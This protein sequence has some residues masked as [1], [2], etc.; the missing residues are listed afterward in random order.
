MDPLALLQ[1]VGTS[2]HIKQNISKRA[3]ISCAA[4]LPA[5]S[6]SAHALDF[7]H[8]PNVASRAYYFFLL[9]DKTENNMA[10][11]SYLNSPAAAC[12]V[13]PALTAKQIS[14]VEKTWKPVEEGIG[15]FDLGIALFKKY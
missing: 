3:H 1:W 6:A 15:F 4:L 8:A 14:L 9:E 11:A 12:A 7:D 10:S 5:S 13:A 2:Y